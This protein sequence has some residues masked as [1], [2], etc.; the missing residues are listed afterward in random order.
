M[1]QNWW[2]T[3]VWNANFFYAAW[4]V[5]YIASGII[6]VTDFATVQSGLCWWENIK[7][8]SSKRLVADFAYLEEGQI[9]APLD[10]GDLQVAHNH[11]AVLIEL[12]QRTVLLVQVRGTAQLVLCARADCKNRRE[13]LKQ[14][15][16]NMTLEAICLLQQNTILG[17]STVQINP[18]QEWTQK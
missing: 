11:F 14:K 1:T 4:A 5:T 12:L 7:W 17:S 15:K 13:I 16:R 18:K 9:A 10:A 2:L 8:H 3:M 6:A